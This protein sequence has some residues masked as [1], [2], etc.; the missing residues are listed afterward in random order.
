MFKSGEFYDFEFIDVAITQSNEKGTPGI[1]FTLKVTD[2]EENKAMQNIVWLSDTLIKDGKNV[3]KTVTE[4][5]LEQLQESFGL[6]ESMETDDLR[7]HYVGKKGRA[8]L[9]NETYKGKT[10]LKVK[11]MYSSTM[12]NTTVDPQVLAKLNGILGQFKPVTSTPAKGPKKA[13]FNK[14]AG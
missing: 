5:N 7:A 11:G 3:G 2:G 6:P 10:S 1:A 12:K 14:K 4:A 13:F 9:E 8:K